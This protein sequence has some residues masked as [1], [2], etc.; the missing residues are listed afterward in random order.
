MTSLISFEIHGLAGRSQP[1]AYE[2]A[3]DLNVFFGLNGSGKTSL[4]KI[5]YAALRN[6]TDIIAR[7]PFTEARVTF[8]STNTGVPITRSIKKSRIE[9]HQGGNSWVE[10]MDEET[11]EMRVMASTAATRW[12][13]KSKNTRP[14][15]VTYLPT[16]RL[17]G[18]SLLRSPAEIYASR[19][20]P[21]DESRLDEAFAEEVLQLW[22]RYTNRLLSDVRSI[23]EQGLSSILQSLFTHETAAARARR[24]QSTEE[25]PA[26]DAKTAYAL[27]SGFMKR[28]GAH[29]PSSLA[30]FRNLYDEDPRLRSVVDDINQTEKLIARA[31]KP[32]HQLELLVQQ[33]ITGGKEVVFSDREIL[34]RT[35]EGTDVPLAS[36][37]SG[38]KQLLR[39]LVEAIITEHNSIIIDE[40]ELSMHIDWQH[41]LLGGLRTLN[42]I[43]QIIVAT[44]SPE[45]MAD[46]P[47]DKIFR[48]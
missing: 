12:D 2:L 29:S 20:A 10:V 16:A 7:V 1:V 4:L 17:A 42:P 19:R 33:F 9:G 21:I 23:Q 3:P 43:A 22:R 11:G 45:I 39:I 8:M 13:S 27:T 30:A 46:V 44:H 24:A 14:F 37:S 25:R 5:L 47:D 34:V 36:L 38:E 31:E 41:E 32:R 48:L 6:R 15:M 18:P 28:Q 35:A 40:P 26:L